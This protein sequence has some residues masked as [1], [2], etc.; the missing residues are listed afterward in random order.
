MP[1]M[2]FYPILAAWILAGTGCLQQNLLAEQEQELRAVRIIVKFARSGI[3]PTE[4]RLVKELSQDLQCALKPLQPAADNTQ[5]YVCDSK[6]SATRFADRLE[7]LAERPDIE[8][9]EID[10]KRRALNN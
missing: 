2:L 3:D 10:A 8:Y 5:V 4:P 1:N 9:A 6:E 7:R